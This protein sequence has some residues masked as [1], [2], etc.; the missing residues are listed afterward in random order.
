MMTT[1]DGER[2]Y[3]IAFGGPPTPIIGN[4][5]YNTAENLVSTA[6]RR[7]RELKPDMLLGGHPEAQFKGKIDAMRAG[8]R[9]HPLLTDAA[10]WKTSLDQAEAGYKVR[11]AAAKASGT[12]IIPGRLPAP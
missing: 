5:K 9:P 4:V 10:A 1:K 8:Q 7:L 11:L 6:Y 12:G 2:S 3:Q